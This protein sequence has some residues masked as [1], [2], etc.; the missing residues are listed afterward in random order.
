MHPSFGIRARVSIV[1]MCNLMQRSNVWHLPSHP[2]ISMLEKSVGK[3]Q[4]CSCEVQSCSCDVACPT[5]KFGG[6][7]GMYK[8]G[9][10]MLYGGWVIGPFL[11]LKLG[12]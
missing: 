5:L 1:I 6:L 11:G 10:G 2:H 7:E 12:A 8:N 4:S 9:R 3:V